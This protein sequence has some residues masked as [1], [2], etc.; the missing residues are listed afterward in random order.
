MIRS[1]PGID[2]VVDLEDPILE[3]ETDGRF[4]AP[5]FIEK[6]VIPPG[7]ELLQVVGNFGEMLTAAAGRNGSAALCGVRGRDY[8]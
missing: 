3:P 1:Q 6:I 7:N 2:H 5:G 4:L 8:A